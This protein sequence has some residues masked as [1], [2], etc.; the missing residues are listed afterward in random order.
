MARQPEIG[1]PERPGG[2]EEPVARSAIARGLAAQVRR[3]RDLRFLVNK[4]IF[5]ALGL[6]SLCAE[7][8][9]GVGDS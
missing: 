2:G 4:K 7:T 5:S 6:G 1:S 3:L 8:V 9:E